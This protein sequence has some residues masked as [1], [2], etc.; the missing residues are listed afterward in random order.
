[1]N[2]NCKIGLNTLPNVIAEYEDIMAILM[3]I[4][5]MNV[6]KNAK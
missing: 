5:S 4:L 6:I 2:N 3:E 1:M